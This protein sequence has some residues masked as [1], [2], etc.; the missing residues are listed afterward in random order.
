MLRLQAVMDV[1]WLEQ[2]EADVAPNDDWFSASEKACLNAHRFPKRRADWRLG[3]WTAKRALAVYWNKPCSLPSL[4][5][6][7]IRPA[8]S[9]AP[10]AFFEAKPAGVTISISHRNG[11]A[12]CTIAAPAT[13]LG[14][15]LEL[16][17]PHSEAFVADYFTE[18][19][20]A[21]IA[22]FPATDEPQLLA[23]LWS[24]KES[25]L[26]ALHEGLRR[27]TRSV[28][29]SLGNPAE[30]SEVGGRRSVN[31]ALFLPQNGDDGW[32]SLNVRSRDGQI[33]HGWWRKAGESVRTIVAAPRPTTPIALRIPGELKRC[34]HVGSVVSG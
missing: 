11:T 27:D 34:A 19:E 12:L 29:V 10:E 3:R 13:Q 22:R 26:K 30:A 1:F 21:L 17:E 15:D 18:E 7:E 20:Q 6:I 32:H 28:I 14:C 25:A 8:P 2:D 5:G 24:A 33:F 23:L 4:A 16:V 31:P 9:G